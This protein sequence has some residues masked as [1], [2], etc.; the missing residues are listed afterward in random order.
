MN[1]IKVLISFLICSLLVVPIYAN[2]IINNETLEYNNISI[3]NFFESH[4]YDVE[5]IAVEKKVI[6]K[7]DKIIITFS[8][9]GDDNYFMQ[10]IDGEA[11][12]SYETLSK[13][14]Q[15]NKSLI[16]KETDNFINYS[17]PD[18]YEFHDDTMNLKLIFFGATWCPYCTEQMEAIKTEL[19]D[20]EQL[21]FELLY[22]SVDTDK[23][24]IYSY[25]DMYNINSVLHD[26]KKVLLKSYN[27]MTIP[28]LVFIKDNRIIDIKD[29]ILTID[30]IMGI[31]EANETILPQA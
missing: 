22:V 30:E 17:L 5:W 18:Y 1:K 28:T 13:I 2:E 4:N 14:Y 16:F 10:L 29:S 24:E 8:E 3:R 6:V 15:E 31:F 25:I 7:S 19:I 12:L 21:L 27:I 26:P 23:E 20:E 9:S 11:Y